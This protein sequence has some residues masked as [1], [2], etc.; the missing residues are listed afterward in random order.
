MVC[1]YSHVRSTTEYESLELRILSEAQKMTNG[2][3]LLSTETIYKSLTLQKVM[4]SAWM[5]GWCLSTNSTGWLSVLVYIRW[6]AYLQKASMWSSMVADGKIPSI[7]K[8]VSF[9][10][11]GW[12][13]HH[14][15]HPPDAIVQKALQYYVS[16]RRRPG[17]L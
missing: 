15:V 4:A 5:T 17:D 11:F 14:H 7:D 6:C 9:Q 12:P 3:I 2:A 13:P 10:T 16:H 1:I 8:R